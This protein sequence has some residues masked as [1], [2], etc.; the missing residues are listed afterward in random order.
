ETVEVTDVLP[1][2]R[3]TKAATPTSLPEPGG[4]FSYTLTIENTSAEAVTITALTDTN[5][6]SSQCLAL[7]NTSLAVGASTSCEYTVTRTNAGT[8]PNTADVTVQDNEG[9]PASDT[10]QQSVT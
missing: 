2:V 6:L 4:V 8:Y 10:A 3:L 1:T 7:I 9:N 5:A